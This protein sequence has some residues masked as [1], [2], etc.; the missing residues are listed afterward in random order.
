LGIIFC[1][2]QSNAALPR[3]VLSDDPGW[4]AGQSA[5]TGCSGG[6]KALA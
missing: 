3:S 5:R 4:Q 1:Q 2:N 6:S